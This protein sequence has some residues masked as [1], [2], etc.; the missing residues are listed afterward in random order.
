MP[1]IKKIQCCDCKK[2]FETEKDRNRHKV[3][4]HG[5]S[6]KLGCSKKSRKSKKSTSYK[7]T[8]QIKKNDLQNDY[9]YF[10][11]G[12]NGLTAIDALKIISEGGMVCFKLNKQL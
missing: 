6:S 7:A 4:V 11:F 8:S 10:I 5:H 2:L 1:K 12:V 9:P 3:I